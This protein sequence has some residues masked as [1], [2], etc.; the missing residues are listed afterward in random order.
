ML[1]KYKNEIF[2]TLLNHPLGFNNF[3]FE[4]MGMD[5]I[6]TYKPY[7][8]IFKYAF[9]QNTESFDYFS[10]SA[11]EYSPLMSA[12]VRVSPNNPVPFYNVLNDFST[13]IERDIQQYLEDESEIDLWEEYKKGTNLSDVTALIFEDTTEFTFEEK[14]QI[15]ISLRELKS[16]IIERF[17]QNDNDNALIID[18]ITY[19]EE[20]LDRLNKTDWKGILI[21]T[22]FAIVIALSLDTERGKELYNLFLMVFHIKPL[23]GI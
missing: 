15:K 9:S 21:S 18:R 19:L 14:S 10:C 16:L 6:V 5:F 11:I 20:S 4:E 22:F 23:L 13:W 3:T 8:G 12:N 1:K 7:N 17:V 2:Q